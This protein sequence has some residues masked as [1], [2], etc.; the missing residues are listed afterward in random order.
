MF[1]FSLHRH[2]NRKKDIE[3]EATRLSQEAPTETFEHEETSELVTEEEGKPTCFSSVLL[4]SL[5]IVYTENKNY[6]KIP[7]VDDAYQCPIEGCGKTYRKENLAQMHVKHYHPEYTKFLDSTPNV[8]DLA[9]ARTVGESLDKSP[10][11]K[12]PVA[13]PLQKSTNLRSSAKLSQ[14]PQMESESKPQSPL[15]SK[16]KDSEIIKLLNTKPFD[17]KKDNDAIK[18]LPA[19]LPSNMYPDIKLKELSE[20]TDC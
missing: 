1:D 19:G 7:I 17:G 5:V 16:N 15:P 13:K 8:A 12:T 11:V 9:Y 3:S 14:S 6:L 18:P 4:N 2:R 10:G 20:N